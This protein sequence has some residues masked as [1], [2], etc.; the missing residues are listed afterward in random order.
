MVLRTVARPNN[1][2]HSLKIRMDES[3]EREHDPNKRKQVRQ[4]HLKKEVPLEDIS[5]IA[6]GSLD[7]GE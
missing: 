2:R 4:E 3:A 6:C 1:H 7:G 5:D